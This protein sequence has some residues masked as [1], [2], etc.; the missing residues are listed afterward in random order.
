MTTITETTRSQG[1]ESL[2]RILNVTRL[3]LTN[4]F[5][6]MV[7][8]L[9]IL[10]FIFLINY[11]IWWLLF[12]ALDAPSRL[13]VADGIQVSGAS[14]FI[15]IY[16]LVVAVQAVNLTFPFALG[17]SVTRRDFYLGS[18]VAFVLLSAFYAAIMTVMAVLE[19][20]TNGWGLGG[21]MFDVVYF[22]AENPLL[23]FVLFLMIFLFFFFI[24]AATAAVYV[25]WRANGMYVFFAS[26]TLIV[27]GL[28]ALITFTGNWPSVGAWFIAN[29]SM[30]VALWT[31][32][33]TT[34]EVGS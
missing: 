7:L 30:G 20:L 34:L 21:A 27:I 5:S 25:R 16:M 9:L 2:A 22:R 3:H 12:G 31:L 29:G 11:I 14:T 6:I 1:H 15:F 4:K 26:L 18:C 23:Q 33:P 32:L 8:P 10:A 28:V 17:Y 13:D 24:G 19:R